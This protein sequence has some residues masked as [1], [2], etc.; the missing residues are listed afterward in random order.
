MLILNFFALLFRKSIR[1]I[2]HIAMSEMIFRKC[3]VAKKSVK[4]DAF[5]YMSTLVHTHAHLQK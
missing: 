2:W 3:F 1:F 4:P 5:P